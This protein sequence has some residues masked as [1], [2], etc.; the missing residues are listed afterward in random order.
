VESR[1]LMSETA[2][3]TDQKGANEAIPADQKH[4]HGDG[5]KV[6]S[7]WSTLAQVGNAP[8]MARMVGYSE[9]REWRLVDEKSPSDS[10]RPYFM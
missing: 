10:L 3:L 2:Q 8:F 5:K 7:F 4:S 1:N 6:Y 9:T